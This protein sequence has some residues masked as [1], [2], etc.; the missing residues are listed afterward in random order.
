M[1]HLCDNKVAGP[2]VLRD[3]VRVFG[4][5]ASKKEF[6]MARALCSQVRSSLPS[7]QKRNA[8]TSTQKAFSETPFPNALPRGPWEAS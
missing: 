3:N 2:G 4:K 1:Q 8:P 6:Q 5:G 7:E